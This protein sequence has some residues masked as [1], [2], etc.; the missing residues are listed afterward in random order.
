MPSNLENS[1]MLSWT[2]KSK[3]SKIN[4]NTSKE[5]IQ[6]TKMNQ[7]NL[8]MSNMLLIKNKMYLMQEE[9]KLG[10]L[11]R[12]EIN[13]NLMMLQLVEKDWSIQGNHYLILEIMHLT[14]MAIR[15][16]LM[17]KMET[18]FKTSG[19]QLRTQTGRRPR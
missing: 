10:Y 4:Q 2:V 17:T 8:S 13:W 9:T 19:H 18:R 1:R 7:E 15:F 12:K 14:L 11:I 16:K 3:L 5:D 6:K